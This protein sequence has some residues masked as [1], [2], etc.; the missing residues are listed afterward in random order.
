[1]P[2]VRGIILPANRQP[3]AEA[4][5]NT[6]ALPSSTSTPTRAKKAASPSRKARLKAGLFVH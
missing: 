4:A 5:G 6:P 3:G 1:L 2:E